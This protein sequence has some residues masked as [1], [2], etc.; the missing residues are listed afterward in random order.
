[1]LNL[2]DHGWI[3]PQQ[4][5][6]VADIGIV[7]TI[8]WVHGFVNGVVEHDAEWIGDVSQKSKTG[9]ANSVGF[10][11]SQQIDLDCGKPR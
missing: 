2:V 4:V 1:V 3:F 8:R 6:R 11:I 9:D 7:R 10:G 5:D